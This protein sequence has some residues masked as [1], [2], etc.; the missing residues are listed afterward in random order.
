MHSPPPEAGLSPVML[1]PPESTR[2]LEAPGMGRWRIRSR[3][4]RPQGDEMQSHIRAALLALACT[5]LAS[6]QP[7][8]TTIQDTLYRAD[9]SRFSG[10][11]FINWNSFVSGSGANV[12]TSSLT[13]PIVN[14]VLRVDL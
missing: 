4:Q 1:R 9:G 5:A 3:V 12:A 13:V 8:L 10:T 11:L 6:A 2:R 7:A 14:G